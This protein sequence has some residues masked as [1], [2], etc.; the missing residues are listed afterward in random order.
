M[1]APT[2]KELKDAGMAK[3]LD[4]AGEEWESVNFANLAAFCEVRKEIGR[5]YFRAEEYREFAITSGLPLPP[6]SQCWGA[7]FNAA[8][9]PKHGLIKSTKKYEPAQ[10]PATHGHPV[11]VW[12]AV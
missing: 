9:K 12:F 4:H 8:A 1:K 10:S 6:S 2:G 5:P 11:L 3:A 7:F